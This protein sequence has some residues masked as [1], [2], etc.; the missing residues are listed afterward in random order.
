MPDIWF[1]WWE[2]RRKRERATE[3]ITGLA[4]RVGV[5]VWSDSNTREEMELKRKEYFFAGTRL[6][7]IVDPP[8]RVVEV[9]TAP[10]QYVTLT[11]EQTLDGGD[12][13]PGFKLPLRNLFSGVPQAPAGQEAAKRR[14]RQ[15]SSALTSV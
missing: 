10:D 7:W 15:S 4:P 1:I 3:P 2:Q 11:E 6:V 8:R 5:E 9:Y 12:V 14:R 13:L